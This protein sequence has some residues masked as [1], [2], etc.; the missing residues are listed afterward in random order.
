MDTV[1]VAQRRRIPPVIQDLVRQRAG[2]RCEYCHTSEQWQYI[3]F[4][5]DHII[6]LARGGSDNPD[7]LALAC[8]HGN[9]RKADRL[10]AVDPDSGEV[11]IVI[12]LCVGSYWSLV[13]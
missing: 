5:V 8:F 13:R 12:Y 9:R 3:P 1:L 4:M 7:N 10:T 11:L 2:R 6:P